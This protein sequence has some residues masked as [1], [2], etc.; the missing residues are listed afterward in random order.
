MRKDIIQL[1]NLED[2]LRNK[3]LPAYIFLY[4]EEDFLVQ[5]A[6]RKILKI[7]LPEKIAGLNYLKWEGDF[8]KFDDF[9]GDLMSYPLLSPFKISHC[10][11]GELLFKKKASTSIQKKL[12]HILK[13]NV[14]ETTLV[15]IT[16]AGPVDKLTKLFK[17]IKAA[18]EVIEFPVFKTY[19][20]G[21]PQKDAT[22]PYLQQRLKRHHC[23]LPADAFF[24]LRRRTPDNLWALINEID[25]LMAYIGYEQTITVETVKQVTPRS[26]SEYIFDFMDT[27]SERKLKESLFLFNNLVRHESSLL[28]IHQMLVNHIHLLFMAR[29]WLNQVSKGSIPSNF[30]YNSLCQKYLPQ[31]N[32]YINT[33][34]MGNWDFLF[35]RHPYLIYKNFLS[36]LKFKEQALL[37]VITKMEQLEND[38]KSKV[39]NHRFLLEMIFMKLCQ[40]Q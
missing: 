19:H 32:K 13:S 6:A 36:A 38:V 35:K 21:D 11:Q 5:D 39:I 4:G 40:N 26:K 7:L 31:W 34:E 24:E 9:L 12:L 25:K 33:G 37:D 14:P 17:M 28:A 22:Y 23:T 30:S 29:Q 2:R 3:Q 15:L 10:A 1:R 20:P 18:G 27:I 8:D 16:C